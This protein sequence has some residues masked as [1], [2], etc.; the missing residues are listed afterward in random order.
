MHDELMPAII[1][2]LGLLIV[3]FAGLRLAALLLFFQQEEYD[4]RRF[5]RW[6]RKT[7]A[8]DRWTSLAAAIGL[9]LGFSP[10]GW[11]Q[12]LGVGV[13]ALGLIEGLRRS[14]RVLRRAKKPLRLTARARRILTL[15]FLFAIA[16]LGGL[17][18]AFLSL[19]PH[20][21]VP[22]VVTGV[23]TVILAQ[24]AP[25]LLVA[26][27]ALLMP[28]ERRIQRRY[29]AEAVAR[30]AAVDPVI[31]GITGSFG[32]TSTKHILGHLLA[33]LG[34]TLITPGSVNTE[35]GIVRIIRERLEPRHRF[36]VVEMGAYGE[37]AIANLCRLTPPRLG[38][39]T[40]VGEAHYERF[41]NL[42][43]VARAKMELAQAVW[44]TGGAL[45]AV[46]DGI[47]DPALRQDLLARRHAGRVVRVGSHESCDWRLLDR[48]EDEDG[49]LVDLRT[50]AGEQMRWRVPLYGRHQAWNLLAAAAAAHELGMPPAA[51]AGA[52]ASL[53]PVAHRLA[54]TRSAAGVTVIDDAY[55]SNPEGFRSALDLLDR[56][57]RTQKGR[58]ILLTPGMVELGARHDKAHR[59]LGRHAAGR[60]DIALLV[61]PERFPSFEEG[62]RAGT[63]EHMPQIHHFARQAEAEAWLRAHARAGDVV[64]VE[65]NLPDLHESPPRF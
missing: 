30:L 39:L 54:V 58:R 1:L 3:A 37:G 33:G 12:G 25:W 10:L 29:R 41:R 63:G 2:L 45:I 8:R 40:A 27:N 11:A 32:K 23:V 65:N 55:N 14:L 18:L 24:T 50:P 61:R 47:A 9:V 26:A 56:L 19:S 20:S 16:G 4:G 52:L 7:G 53:Q 15:A 59:A 64:L 57:G 6:V 44:N 42:E 31:L 17:G 36:F 48:Q 5:L 49:L 21:P 35:M 38:I 43:T 28:L 60:V 13:V 46:I 62:L 22:A 51:I 34:P